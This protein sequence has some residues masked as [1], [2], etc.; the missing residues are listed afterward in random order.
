VTLA[1][2][3][4]RIGGEKRSAPASSGRQWK[5]FAEQGYRFTSRPDSLSSMLLT[6]LDVILD[7]VVASN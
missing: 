5:Y 6:K 4:D 1:A 2:G 7:G 3:G